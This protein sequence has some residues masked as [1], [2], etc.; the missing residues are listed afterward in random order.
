VP[1]DTSTIG[2]NTAQLTGYDNAGNVVTI[3]C[4][5]QVKPSYTFSGYVAPINNPPTVNTGKGGKVYPVKWQLR[6]SNGS[7]VSSLSVV[8]GIVVQPSSCGAFSNDPTDA[9]ETTS[10]GS[11]LRYD[12][13]TTTYI[14]NWATPGKGCYTLFLKL[15][16]GQVFPAFFNLF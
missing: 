13:S 6:D 8:A 2:Q 4:P 5:Y 16:S 15:D 14:Y 7:F 12:S 10:T 11:G 1:A 9:I 3:S